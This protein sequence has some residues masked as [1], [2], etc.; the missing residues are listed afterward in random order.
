MS[1]WK[2][3]GHVLVKSNEQ[4]RHNLYRGWVFVNPKILKSIQSCAPVLVVWDYWNLDLIKA[5]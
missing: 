4:P 5:T 1:N 2:G 3:G